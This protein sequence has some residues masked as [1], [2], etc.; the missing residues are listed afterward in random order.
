MTIGPTTPAASPFPIAPAT[1]GPPPSSAP[2]T[3]PWSS[4]PA[5]TP[6]P[7]FAALLAGELQ[8]AVERLEGASANPPAGG[9]AGAAAHAAAGAAAHAAAHLA[10]STSVET[11]ATTA[12]DAAAAAPAPD[13]AAKGHGYVV[14][15]ADGATPVSVGAAPAPFVKGPTGHLELTARTT[16][17]T[18][19]T[20]HLTG[21]VS[22]PTA[23]A[24]A[25]PSVMAAI[26]ALQA[27]GQA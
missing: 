6:P 16:G 19:L 22:D 17:L 26:A 3:T 27:D 9:G 2:A 25:T 23:E 13:P 15:Y 24:K 10:A 11:E 21:T 7:S 18:Q 20:V 12:I 4:A 1:G 8:T 5:T 14:R